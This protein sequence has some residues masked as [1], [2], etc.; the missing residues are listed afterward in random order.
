MLTW[1]V[2]KGRNSS[3]VADANVSIDNRC[4]TSSPCPS[5][6]LL[7][8]F[9]AKLRRH[10]CTAH[11]PCSHVHL[12]LSFLNVP[13]THCL[14]RCRRNLATAVIHMP[15]Y[16][17]WR[18]RG[19][20]VIEYVASSTSYIAA[21]LHRQY[22]SFHMQMTR[23]TQQGAHHNPRAHPNF[24]VRATTSDCPTWAQHHG[25]VARAVPPLPSVRAST[26]ALVP[27]F[28]GRER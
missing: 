27:S 12:R 2:L 14:P 26:R 16:I 7:Q 17:H 3:P 23:G 13:A 24:L 21:L 18:R 10:D 20:L 4:S 22:A 15:I 9:G 19:H 28:R 6:T 1:L 5:H 25:R 11:T 8:I